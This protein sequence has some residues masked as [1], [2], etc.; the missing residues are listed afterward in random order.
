[1]AIMLM[2][3]DVFFGTVPDLDVDF[4]ARCQANWL[5]VYRNSTASEDEF[6]PIN[7]NK[8]T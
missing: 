5:G 3:K 2:T 1:M 6:I 8:V 4:N 7:S